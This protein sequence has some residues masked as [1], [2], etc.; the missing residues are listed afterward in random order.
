MTSASD[1]PPTS[2]F[3][4]TRPRGARP[5]LHRA[6][7]GRRGFNSRAREGRDWGLML[8]MCWRV[9]FNSRAREGRDQLS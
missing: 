5:T 8:T 1:A 7:R 9:R 2:P 6:R 3:Q 4:L